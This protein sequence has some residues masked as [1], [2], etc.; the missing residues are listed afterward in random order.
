MTS[1]RLQRHQI[2]AYSR[3]W[4]PE[5]MLAFLIRLAPRGVGSSLVCFFS[6][7]VHADNSAR[8]LSAQLTSLC[9]R[10]EKSE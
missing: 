4:Q 10:V 9:H 8:A 7:A 6:P 3:Q 5:V 2:H 1:A